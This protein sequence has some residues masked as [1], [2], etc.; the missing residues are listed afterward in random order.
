MADRGV[1][2]A[3]NQRDFTQKAEATSGTKEKRLEIG[4]WPINPLTKGGFMMKSY[5]ISSLTVL[6]ALIFMFGCAPH[7]KVLPGA[8]TRADERDVFKWLVENSDEY[9][10]YGFE[11]NNKV[12]ALLFDP[13]ADNNTIQVTEKWK[14]IPDKAALDNAIQNSEFLKLHLLPALYRIVGPSGGVWAYIASYITQ[15]NTKVI[16]EKTLLVLGPQPPATR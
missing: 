11:W 4:I 3:N 16:D 14:R 9:H 13:K 12:E 7:A 5:I 15:V 10:V 2:W 1:L 8:G 6:T